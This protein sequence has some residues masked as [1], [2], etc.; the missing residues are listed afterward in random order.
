[1]TTQQARRLKPPRLA[2]SVKRPV[3]PGIAR[4]EK[5]FAGERLLAF[6]CGRRRLHD[7]DYE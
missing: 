4:E 5:S 6:A 1:M 7:T 3:E 2:S